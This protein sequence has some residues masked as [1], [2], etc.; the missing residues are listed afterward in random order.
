MQADGEHRDRWRRVQERVAEERLDGVLVWS[1]GG[2]IADSFA[3]VLYLAN[4]YS[5]FPLI[6]DIPSQW[7]GRAHSAVLL[8]AQ[9]EPTLIVDH[10]D[11]RRDQVAVEDVRFTLDL[12][13]AAAD[14]LRERG[15]AGG[16]IGLVG[17][18]AMLAGVKDRLVEAAAGTELVP[19]DD[20]VERLRAVKSPAE[21]DRLRASAAMGDRVVG[22]VIEAALRP[23]TTEAEAVA[24]GYSIAV[25]EGVAIYDAAIASGPNS[26]YYAYGRLPSWTRRRLEAG[27]IF[28]IDT[29][30]V[31]D[32]YLYDFARCCV[33][34]GQPTDDQVTVMEAVIDA[35]HAG[36]DAVA[37]G[38][39][40]SA[41]Y[42]AVHSVL[43]EREMTPPDDDDAPVLSALTLSFPAHGHSYGMGWERPWFVAGNDEPLV[44]GMCIGV[45]G[46]AG[47]PGVGS[48]KFEQDVI[49]TAEG[50][51]LIT[52]L[53]THFW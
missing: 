40:V 25:A 24:A 48:A 44:E 37:P 43:V 32:G 11:W 29:Y 26:D 39:P 23:G 41:I 38:I 49:V 51:E 18:N 45:E 8:P 10:P 13:Q 16:R 30:G 12:P 2:G 50:A 33:S 7:A 42:D 14:L 19:V 17:R 21:L 53:D 3:D 5:P 1:R 28:H 47:R 52:K 4:H 36:V 27:D 6:A 34:G 35:V 46:M 9:G 22:A 20:L 15:L 31:L